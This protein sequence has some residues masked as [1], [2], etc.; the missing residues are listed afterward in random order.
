MSRWQQRVD[1][2][3]Y[4][5]ESVEQT[6]DVGSAHVVVTSH[7]VL[8]FTPD[9]EGENF[10][11]VDR[12]NVEGVGTGSRTKSDILLNYGIKAAVYGLLLVAAGYIIDFDSIIGGIDIGAAGST[13][14]LGLGGL[15][16]TT[17]AMIDLLSRLDE[18][19]LLFGGLALFLGVVF[20]GVF[21]YQRDP[22]LVIETAGES[23]DIHVP[24]PADD[25]ATERLKQAVR[26][27]GHAQPSPSTSRDSDL[28]L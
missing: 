26:P 1:D 8:A 2:L 19:M 10:Q 21:W 25:A 20:L 11:Q 18:L 17:Q 24:K 7:R 14:K 27:G 6:V 15:L 12:P 3:L 5:G 4:D 16:E 13:G 9:L 22:T 23:D 28:E